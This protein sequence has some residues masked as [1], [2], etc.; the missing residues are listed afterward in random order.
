M[1]KAVIFDCFGVLAED[2]WLPFKRQYIGSNKE[3][4][5]VVHD[6]GKQ[7]DY[8]M[9]TNDEYFARAAKLIGVEETALRSAIGR[10]KP[11]LQMFDYIKTNLK[12]RC[13]IGLLSNAN[14]DVVHELFTPEQAE[15][16]DAYVLSYESKL[17]KPD[18]RMFE[19]MA[20]RLGVEVEECVLVDDVERYCSAAEDAGLAS[21]LYKSPEQAIES[22]ERIL[23]PNSDI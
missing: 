8:G 12:K 6:L 2:G 20:E 1:I 11:N 22:I 17:V 16:F 19:L 3:L 9:I 18:P 4:E 14:F 23:A 7:N 5:L 10:R 13:K 21:I 15:L